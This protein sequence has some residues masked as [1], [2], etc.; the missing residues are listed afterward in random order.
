MAPFGQVIPVQGTVNG[1]LGE[2][3]RSGGGDPFIVSKPA[4]ANNAAN[5]NFGDTVV[6]L[7]DN[8]GGTYKQFADWQANGGG[9]A[10]NTATTSSSATATP[11]TLA[12]ISAGMFVFGAG[13]S[14]GTFVLSV[15][16]AAGTIT[17]SKTATATAGAA[18]L[19]YAIFAGI[20]VREVKTTPGY[21]ISGQAYATVGSYTPGQMCGVLVR[22]GIIVN[23]N[24]GVQAN[25]VAGGPAYLRTILNGTFPNAVVGDLESI[26]DT[27]NSVLLAG[28]AFPALADGFWKTG[29]IDAN[30]AV[31]LIFTSRITV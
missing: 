10:I 19:A 5:I 4:N 24:T 16:Y 27:T 13:I 30:N 25:C 28:G 22:G 7:P 15:N 6:L 8:T 21:V 9:L 14:A 12:G 11:S 26:S 23:I 18:A 31:E 17:L 2:V 3:T 20:A 1:F 29:H